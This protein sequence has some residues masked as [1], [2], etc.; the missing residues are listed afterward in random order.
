MLIINI[1]LFIVTVF[2]TGIAKT[3]STYKHKL[4]QHPKITQIVGEQKFLFLMGIFCIIV[5]EKYQIFEARSTQDL[6]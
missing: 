3:Q 5:Q 6:F 4:P 2:F 1:L